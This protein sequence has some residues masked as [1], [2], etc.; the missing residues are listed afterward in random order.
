MSAITRVIRERTGDECHRCVE[1]AEPDDW[2]FADG[3]EM[4]DGD[5]LCAECVAEHHAE[6]WTDEEAEALL[7]EMRADEEA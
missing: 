6:E 2:H 5:W 7:K 3:V 4:I 1:R